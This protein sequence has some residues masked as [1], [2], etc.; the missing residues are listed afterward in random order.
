MP[1]NW[2]RQYFFH[3]S[4]MPDMKALSAMGPAKDFQRK[5]WDDLN[6]IQRNTVQTS[7]REVLKSHKVII[8][9]IP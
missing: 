5:E 6:V 1:L 4:C 3:V 9:H 7:L 8:T 2:H